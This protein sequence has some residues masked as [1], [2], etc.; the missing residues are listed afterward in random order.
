[1]PRFVITTQYLENYGCPSGTSNF[2]AGGFYWRFKPGDDYLVSGFD[3]IQ[4]AVA[5]ITEKCCSVAGEAGKEFPIKWRTEL[6]WYEELGGVS[7]D[8]VEYLLD[9]VYKVEYKES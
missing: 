1:M 7:E 9:T 3:R 8:Y 5:Y 2:E 4:D 6:E